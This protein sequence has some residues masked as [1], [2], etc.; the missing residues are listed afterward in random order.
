MR[1]ADRT[2]R[3]VCARC[4]FQCKFCQLMKG[5]DK[6]C[7]L[8]KE[9]LNCE[10]SIILDC[11]VCQFHRLLAMT[12]IDLCAQQIERMGRVGC[13]PACSQAIACVSLSLQAMVD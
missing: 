4:F 6:S 5:F 3:A 1:A 10:L 8:Y 2:S 12:L 13:V 11:I 9:V 7:K